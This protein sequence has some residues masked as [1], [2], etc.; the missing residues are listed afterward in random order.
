[1]RVLEIG[2]LRSLKLCSGLFSL[3]SH[4]TQK[5]RKEVWTEVVS[6]LQ[7]EVV[8]GPGPGG[9]ARVQ[10]G[11]PGRARIRASQGVLDVTVSRDP[12]L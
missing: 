1:M 10:A 8:Q 12:G 9:L 6:G 5:S 2:G 11:L 7:A 4:H 3:G